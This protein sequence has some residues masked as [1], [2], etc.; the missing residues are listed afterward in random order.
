[1]PAESQDLLADLAAFADHHKLASIVLAGLTLRGLLEFLEWMFA[2]LVDWVFK[3]SEH[4]DRLATVLPW[5]H[6]VVLW[7]IFVGIA[8]F[9]MFRRLVRQF[10]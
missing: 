2:F 1:M 7:I 4:W 3:M 10:S 5:V 9:L 8:C 6:P